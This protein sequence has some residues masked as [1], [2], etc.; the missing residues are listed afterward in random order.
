LPDPAR[1]GRQAIG[2]TAGDLIVAIDLDE[3][4]DGV[5]EIPNVGEIVPVEVGAS[6]ALLLHGRLSRVAQPA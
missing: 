2:R 6:A 1:R 4:V 5:A 3:G